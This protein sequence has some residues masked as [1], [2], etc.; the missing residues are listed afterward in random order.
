[1]GNRMPCRAPDLETSNDGVRVNAVQGGIQVDYSNGH[2]TLF[3]TQVID[4]GDGSGQGTSFVARDD[5]ITSWEDGVSPGNA[6]DPA[7]PH[8]QT[9]SANQ[10][11]LPPASHTKLN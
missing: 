6:G 9:P 4:L 7:Y 8:A 1:M 5:G 11:D 2:S 10:A 3:V